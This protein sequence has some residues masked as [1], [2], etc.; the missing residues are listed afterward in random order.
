MSTTFARNLRRNATDAEKA[1]WRLLRA[2]QLADFKFRRQQFLGPY[3]VDFVCFSANLV[4]EADGGQHADS[5]TD[6]IRDSWLSAQGFRVLR[7]WDND[8]LINP[9]GIIQ[10]ILAALLG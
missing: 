6:A 9:D 3:I 1:L 7:L 4:I 5:P 2:R 10:T 8:I